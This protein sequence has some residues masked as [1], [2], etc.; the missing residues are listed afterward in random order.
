MKDT[1][2]ENRYLIYDALSI[3]SK[4][5][6]CDGSYSLSCDDDI[7]SL[8]VIVESLRHASES[9][10]ALVHNILENYK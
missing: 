8:I 9:I 3:L 6:K 10:E 4:F 5:S 7:E 2:D 1:T